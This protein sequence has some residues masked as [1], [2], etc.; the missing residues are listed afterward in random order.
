MLRQTRQLLAVSMIGLFCLAG[1]NQAAFAVAVTCPGSPGTNDR[2]FTLDTNPA[3]TCEQFGQGNI[4]GNTNGANPDPFLLA[5]PNYV[6]LDKSDDTVSGLFPNAFDSPGSL[7]TG[8]S[9]TFSFTPPAGFTNFAFGLKSGEG[10][11]DPDW[12]IF[13]LGAGVMSG[14]WSISGNQALS[15]ANLYGIA[16]V[17]LPAALWLFA[18]ALLGL[19]MTRR[20]RMLST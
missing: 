20:R 13:L 17:P 18:S 19:G 4:S 12:A 15:H 2:V 7:T 3:S 1:V 9:G 6:L 11:L 16:A 5:H 14:D 8:N 10:Q